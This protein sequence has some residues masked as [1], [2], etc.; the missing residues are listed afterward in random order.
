[1]VT[2][3]ACASNPT[4]LCVLSLLSLLLSF[5]CLIRAESRGGRGE[6]RVLGRVRGRAKAQMEQEK[7][8]Q[9]RGPVNTC[10]NGV[11]RSESRTSSL[12]NLAES[13]NPHRRPSASVVVT[14]HA[15]RLSASHGHAH[16][17]KGDSSHRRDATRYGYGAHSGHASTFCFR[18]E[19]CG[20]RE[21]RRSISRRDLGLDVNSLSGL[22]T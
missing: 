14:C 11:G 1:M 16:F 12:P 20:R 15:S 10:W 8:G 4:I 21:R 6:G 22:T 7:E 18:D 19:R 5:W 3:A 2:V 17:M 13:T 9:R